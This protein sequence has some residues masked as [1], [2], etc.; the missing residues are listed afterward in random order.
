MNGRDAA[1]AAAVVFHAGAQALNSGK[2]IRRQVASVRSGPSGWLWMSRP[3]WHFAG[4]LKKRGP[5]PVAR[6]RFYN[7]LEPA[8]FLK[9][10]IEN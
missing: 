9:V 1:G 2:W 5:G 8:G 10:E 6:L 7:G 4:E 3:T